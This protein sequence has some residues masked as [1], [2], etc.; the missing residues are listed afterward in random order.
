MNLDVHIYIMML[1]FLVIS[2]I[3]TPSNEGSNYMN[4]LNEMPPKCQN[5]PYWEWAEYPYYCD[6]NWRYDN[7]ILP[8]RSQSKGK[9][10]DDSTRTD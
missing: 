7:N 1:L 8:K 10:L 3:I 4:D 5:C 6:C 9:R 2:G